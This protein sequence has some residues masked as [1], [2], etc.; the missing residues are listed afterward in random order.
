M[1]RTY[2][3]FSLRYYLLA[4]KDLK[5]SRIKEI[6]LVLMNKTTQRM[7]TIKRASFQCFIFTMTSLVSHNILFIDTP[8]ESGS[9]H[10]ELFVG[11]VK[12]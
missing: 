3:S 6:R 12:V 7:C 11:E 2:K 10:F 8:E 4:E 1:K 9:K 5:G